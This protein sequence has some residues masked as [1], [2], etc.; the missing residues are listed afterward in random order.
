[1]FILS[2]FRANIGKTTFAY[3][4]VKLWNKGIPETIKKSIRYCS[5]SKELKQH[6][7]EENKL[8]VSNDEIKEKKLY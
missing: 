8:I 4:G 3:Q 1:M 7:L 2:S 5:F 6:L